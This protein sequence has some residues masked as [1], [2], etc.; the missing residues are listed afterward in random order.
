[1]NINKLLQAILLP[2]LLTGFSACNPTDNTLENAPS[3]VEI[4]EGNYISV[5][6]H[7][8]GNSYTRGTD[9][10]FSD[11]TEQEMAISQIVLT[12]YDEGGN[13]L[14]CSTLSKE[15]VGGDLIVVATHTTQQPR[16]MLA[17]ANLDNAATTLSGLSFDEAITKTCATD[18]YQDT[19]GNF[20]MTTSSY[21]KE[22]KIVYGVEIDKTNTVFSE[23]DIL[24]APAV[25]VYLERLAAKIQINKNDSIIANLPTYNN[26][27]VS[28]EVKGIALNG[29]NKS[30]FYVKN[31]ADYGF[32]SQQW[33][34]EWNVP[35]MHRSYWSTDPNYLEGSSNLNSYN[36]RTYNEIAQNEELTEYCLENTSGD[37]TF[38][39]Q[40]ATHVLVV[41]QYKLEGVKK[42]TNLYL[43]NGKL[44]T[45]KN[46]KE[47]VRSKYQYFQKSGDKYVAMTDTLYT[48]KRNGVMGNDASN[49]K[50]ALKL[51]D[52]EEVFKIVDGAYSPLTV[53]KANEELAKEN[54]AIKYG[55]GK[56][57]Y[58]APIQHLGK[59]GQVGQY[60]VVRNHI[61]QITITS[62]NSF[63]AGIWDPGTDPDEDP[64]TNPDDPSEDPSDNPSDETEDPNPDPD[65][66]TINPDS[67]NPGEPIV[68]EPITPTLNYYVG[69]TI[70]VIGWNEFSQYIDL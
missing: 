40:N 57:Y 3:M 47:I 59:D 16:K 49:V 58:A 69:M 65:D 28:F 55:Q 51:D 35:S 61:Y 62:I 53:A 52:K 27:G 48:I 34:T 33:Y 14:S 41:G 32:S 36:Y 1:M 54:D 12:F 64:S 67:P 6:F 2:T 60:G 23:D 11:G 50:I 29:T 24:E 63:G 45:A 56:C 22:G 70:K 4:E 25:D 31:I 9:T 30:A 20:V 13:Y 44:M 7:I 15:D 18:G 17:W 46:Y 43:Y 5:R 39:I 8:I 37:A 26:K 38:N 66:P 19:N 10:G 42:G 68:P 21:I